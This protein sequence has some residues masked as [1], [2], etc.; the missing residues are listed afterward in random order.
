[1]KDYGVQFAQ[2][3]EAASKRPRWV[4]AILFET[5]SIYCTSHSDITGVPGTVLHG[6][7]KQP[8]AIS[9]RL[10]LGQGRSE[11]GSFSFSLIDIGEGFT[12][13]IRQRLNDAQGLRRRRVKFWIGHEDFDFSA[14]KLFQTQLVEK[15]SVDEGVYSIDCRDITRAQRADV[16]DKLAT[17]T[18]RD[19]FDATATTIPVYFTSRF[20]MVAHGPHW[21]DAPSQ[22]V[23]YIKIE[24]EI[25]RYSGTT[26][27]SF[28]G[29]TRGAMNTKA[30][31]HAV[32]AG[33]SSDRRTK[34][35]EY[36]YLELPAVKLGWAILTGQI[37]GTADVLPDHWHLGIDSADLVESDF[38]GIG[39]DIWDP[40]DDAAGLPLV[41]QGLGKTDG[42]AFLEWEIYLLLNCY[43]P[44]YGDGR[45]GLRRLAAVTSGA[46][47]V[48]T[49]TEDHILQVAPLVHDM[50]D[51]HN[52]FLV[53]WNYDV[54][55]KKFTRYS[56]FVDEDSQ[57]AH[58]SSSI[59]RYKFKGLVG[60]KHTDIS[61]RQIFDCLR[62]AHSTPPETTSVVLPGFLLRLENGDVVRLA[63]PFLPDYAGDGPGIN[64]SFM[65][66]GQSYDAYA[67]RITALLFGSSARAGALAFG[68]GTGPVLPD[69]YYTAEGTPLSS[70]AAVEGAVCSPGCYRLT[71]PSR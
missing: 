62:D 21:S 32:D 1:M 15:V 10:I 55:T 63:L 26:A 54:S 37:Y 65:V 23:G 71:L 34:V 68:P 24:N 49:L 4:V 70:V 45:L 19:S 57:A 33:T 18:L 44:V 13:E 60:S 27:E 16:F 47:P 14:F 38:T 25:I 29:C 42:K 20:E 50:T 61:I 43:Q 56:L 67:D 5:D 2:A 6:V 36:V 22:T 17:T 40:A 51:M 46:A 31:A 53:E 48:T 7:L 39:R 69:G 41:F 11:I 58:G 28:T 52:V 59:T 12:D 9:Q 35:D 64:R 8:S 3:Q 66:V 30:V